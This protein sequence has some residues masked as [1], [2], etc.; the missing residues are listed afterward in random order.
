M[1]VK[2]PNKPA[3]IVEPVPP[4]PARELAVDPPAVFLPSA[5]LGEQLQHLQKAQAEI[6]RGKAEE[7]AHL[8]AIQDRD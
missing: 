8:R 3:P 4:S 7:L 1:S 5:E 2:T 6:D